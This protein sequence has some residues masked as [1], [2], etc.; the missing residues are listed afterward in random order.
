[1]KKF[2]FNISEKE[3][4]ETQNDVTNIS[5]ATN[6]MSHLN[7]KEKIKLNISVKGLSEIQGDVTNIINATNGKRYL[8]KEYSN[9]IF[10]INYPV[11][12]TLEV[13]I[14]KAKSIAD[15]LIPIAKAYKDIIYKDIETENKYGVW[16]HSIQDLY[17]EK[18]TINENGISKLSIGS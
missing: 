5:N 12:T 1:M 7:K 11:S 2:K 17:F 15:I 3:L 13:K 10:I 9:L 16:G 8:N 18:I 14:P 4:L 6:R